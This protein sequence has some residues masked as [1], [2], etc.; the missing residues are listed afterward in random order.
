MQRDPITT[1]TAP[2][3]KG[4]YSQ[5]IRVG[6]FVYTSGFGPHDPQ[7]G[8]IVGTDIATQAAQALRNV[9]AALRAGGSSLAAA[10]KMTVHLAD[11]GDFVA[12]DAAYRDA[13]TEPYPV[14]TTVGST[15]PGILVEIDAVG[16][17]SD[18]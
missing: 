18:G 9:D 4:T 17:V 3:P 2:A 13:M 10:V 8:E 7:T 12:F 11:L 5:A 6:D 16:L 15:L 14:R 1:D